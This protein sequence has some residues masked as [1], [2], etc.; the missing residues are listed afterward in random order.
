MSHDC[1]H[2]QSALIPVFFGHGFPFTSEMWKD[3]VERLFNDDYILNHYALIFPNFIGFGDI[4]K[5]AEDLSEVPAGSVTTMTDMADQIIR[6]ADALFSSKF[7]YCGL[8][9]GGYV[10]WEI[11]NRCQDRLLG[12]IVSDTNAKA[13]SPEGAANRLK[14]A[15]R[16]EQEDSCAFLADAMK[17]NL[18]EPNSQERCPNALKTYYQMVSRNNPPGV[19]AAARGM[20]QRKDFTARLGE[21]QTPALVIGGKDDF[22]SPPESLDALAA[23]MPNATRATV[24]GGHLAPMEHPDEYAEAVAKFL[25]T[26]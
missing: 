5:D 12:L 17:D 1:F 15:D 9:M 7:V 18:F 4:V 3:I 24:P 19:A 6:I 11:W 16:I 22:L 2:P 23:A 20:A 14:T 26:L 25:R 10:G 8:S 13:D 21:I